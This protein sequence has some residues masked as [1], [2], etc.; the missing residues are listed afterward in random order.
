MR[1]ALN[2]GPLTIPMESFS[3]TVRT[4]CFNIEVKNKLAN[5]LCFLIP[6]LKYTN[7]TSSQSLWSSRS[8][9]RAPTRRELFEDERACTH[10]FR[11]GFW[12]ENKRVWAHLS[13]VNSWKLA[14]DGQT[15][16]AL[17]SYR[18][19]AWTPTRCEL[20]EAD[21]CAASLAAR[22]DALLTVRT[23][24]VCFDSLC[25]FVCVSTCA[26]CS[27]SWLIWGNLGSA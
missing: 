5:V 20:F 15:P 22:S 12:D 3:K 16:A 24:I 1:E 17:W 4:F 8:G 7:A 10:C 14:V 23:V 13:R 25:L 9:A 26:A 6:T 11:W 19:S 2:R 27:C 21:V 18:S